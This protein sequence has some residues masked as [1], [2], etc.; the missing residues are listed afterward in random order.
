M[1]KNC[2]SGFCTNLSHSPVDPDLTLGLSKWQRSTTVWSV[3]S[4]PV[5]LRKIRTIGFW[6]RMDDWKME[7][8]T[9]VNQVSGLRTVST[10]FA[11]GNAS[12]ISLEKKMQDTIIIEN[13]NPENMFACLNMCLII[14]L[15]W[16]HVMFGSI[17]MLTCRTKRWGNPPLP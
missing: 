8:L 3:L 9:E 5:I 13:Y 4:F 1:F 6:T 17:S 7:F 11:S 10:S 2:N 16:Q 15:W 14:R 12:I